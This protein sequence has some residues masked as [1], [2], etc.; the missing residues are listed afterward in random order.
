MWTI[1]DHFSL[2]GGGQEMGV[3]DVYVYMINYIV[4]QMAKV[5]STLS[6]SVGKENDICGR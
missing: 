4:N 6:A 3:A 5:F 1:A 2:E